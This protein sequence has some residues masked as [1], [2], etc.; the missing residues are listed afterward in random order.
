M[1]G[2]EI[3]IT[4]GEQVFA[5]V[6]YNSFRVGPFIIKTTIK[7]GETYEQ[8]FERAHSYLMTAARKAYTTER[9]LFFDR[10]DGRDK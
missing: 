8:A 1:E 3:T 9:G 6:S 2:D 10:Y 7:A 5:P 4:L